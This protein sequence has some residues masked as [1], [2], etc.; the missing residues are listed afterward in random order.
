M[1][2]EIIPRPENGKRVRLADNLAAKIVA[3]ILF[4]VMAAAALLS[5]IAVMFLV[6][7]R[8]YGAD[9][10]FYDSSLCSRIAYSAAWRYIYSEG[11]YNESGQNELRRKISDPDWTLHPGNTNLLFVASVVDVRYNE[12]TGWEDRGEPRVITQSCDGDSVG[13]HYMTSYAIYYTNVGRSRQEIQL[14]L[15][16]R[17]P[18]T[19]DDEFVAASR[20]FNFVHANRFNFIWICALSAALA[21]VLFVFLMRAA[22]HRRGREGITRNFIDRIPLD[23]LTAG[24]L[25]AGIFF[26]A[27]GFDSDSIF[28]VRTN[29]AAYFIIIGVDVLLTGLLA[30][31]LCMTLATRIKLGRFWENTI[32]WRFWKFVCRVLKRLGRGLYKLVS[33]L[34][35]TWKAFLAAA[36]I[37][38]VNFFVMAVVYESRELGMGVIALFFIDAAIGAGVIYTTMKIRHLEEAGRRLAGGELDY[39]VDTSK[40]RWN[41]REHGENLNRI[42]DG[43]QKAVEERMKS[44]RLKTELITNVSHDIKTPLTSIINY[45]DILK[46]EGGD[47]EK[48]AQYIEILERQSARL[49]KLTE[50]VIEASKASSG[51][52]AMNTENMDVAELLRQAVGEYGERLAAA[53]VEPVVTS[54]PRAIINADGRLLWR[55]FENLLSNIA[56][57]AQ[58]STRAYF[59]VENSGQYVTIVVRNISRDILAVSPDEL[60]ERFVRGDASRTDG[61]SGLGLAIARSLTELMGGDFQIV[62]DGDLFKVTLS[63]REVS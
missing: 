62:L 24:V 29:G 15:Y 18:L 1:E 30:L 63:F 34:P 39:K 58:P 13:A 10:T 4:V 17:S 22:G 21:I 33:Y 2:N 40:M 7:D 35:F 5:A 52:I 43:M 8:S 6:A 53:G 37:A 48:T 26:L 51:A 11:L 56:R 27:V 49:K 57:Y 55:V 50:D 9:A 38:F 31:M 20:L 45:V 54:A 61:G 12:N 44:E 60:T 32:L 28:A 42:G 36:F 14:D 3:V 25:I 19:A 47:P 59:A 16:V 46:K 41:V 23:L